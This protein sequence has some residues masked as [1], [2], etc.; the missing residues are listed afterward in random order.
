MPELRTQVN[1]L[2]A[3]DLATAA[4]TVQQ[5]EPGKWPSIIPNC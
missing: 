2:L 4:T 1:F 5:L 3:T